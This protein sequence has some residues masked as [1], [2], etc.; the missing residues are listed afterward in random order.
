MRFWDQSH[1]PCW[2]HRELLAAMAAGAIAQ[3]G[4]VTS[5]HPP[6]V[7]AEMMMP[8]ANIARAEVLY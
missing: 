8:D 4:R 5:Y 6:P 1:T 2:A 3:K 7:G